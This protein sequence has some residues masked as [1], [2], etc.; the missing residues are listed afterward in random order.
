MSDKE[1]ALIRGVD[2]SKVEH[3]W[4]YEYELREGDIFLEGGAFMGR[5]IKRASKKVGPATQPPTE[6]HR[7]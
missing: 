2:W 3:I 7:E 5:Y 1:R 4:E 6:T